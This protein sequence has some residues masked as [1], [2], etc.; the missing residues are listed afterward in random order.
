MGTFPA[1]PLGRR[2]VLA[3][4]LAL[5]RLDPELLVTQLPPG[6]RPL[7]VGGSG[8]AAACFTRLGAPR[9]LRRR[10]LESQHLSYRVAVLREQKDGW[11]AGTWIARRETSSWLEAR[12][13]SSFL[14]GQYGRAAFRLK[15]DVFGVELAVHGERG[16]EFYLRAEV[17]AVPPPALFA[18]ARAFEDFL[19]QAGSVAPHDVFAPEADELEPEKCFAPEPLS[20]FEVH[21]TFL[22]GVLPPGTA[23]FD[24]AWRLVS[25]QL[26][27]ARRAR[28]ELDV[29]LQRG[30]TAPALL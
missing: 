22:E 8:V 23:R 28:G 20:V 16:P 2:P 11:H 4:L 17:T 19:G 27:P 10:A 3:R 18:S 7:V 21:S 9:L 5:Y 29:L 6:V 30:E 14:R 15:E 26:A 24:S 13:G 25:R 1:L 12:C